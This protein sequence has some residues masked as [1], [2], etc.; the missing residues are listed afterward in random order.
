MNNQTIP[1]TGDIGDKTTAAGLD[2]AL[3]YE[4]V[5]GPDAG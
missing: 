2:V 5:N 4:A 1:V 3:L